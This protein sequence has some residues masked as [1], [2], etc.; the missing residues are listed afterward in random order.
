MEWWWQKRGNAGGDDCRARLEKVG[1]GGSTSGGGGSG[2]GMT[3]PKK[4]PGNTQHT[5]SAHASSEHTPSVQPYGNPWHVLGGGLARGQACKTSPIQP[6]TAPAP[7]SSLGFVGQLPVPP[8]A[9]PGIHPSVLPNAPTARLD[10][11]AGYGPV[12]QH[13]AGVPARLQRQSVSDYERMFD[14]IERRAG[15]VHPLEPL[16][17]S[18][19]V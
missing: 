9:L 15:K 8:G 14:A 19:D 1:R 13:Q 3:R 17:T 16:A 2:G 18:E 7:G 10:P 11:T 12:Q 4:K 6:K 5:P